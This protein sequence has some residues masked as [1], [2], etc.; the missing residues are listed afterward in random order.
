LVEFC[1][2]CGSL[3]R[4]KSCKCGYNSPELRNKSINGTHLIEIWDPPPPKAIYCKITATP[5]KKLNLMLRKG[6][7]PQKLK[8][9]TSKLKSHHL[10]CLNC[11]YYNI[12][13]SHCQIKNKYLKKDSICRNFEP[14]E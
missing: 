14:F 6:N 9:I 7:Y 12:E 2:D 5:L 8:E 4:K 13:I 1:P 11:V 10:T 3:L